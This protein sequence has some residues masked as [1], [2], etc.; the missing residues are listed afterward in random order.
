M[1]VTTDYNYR[2]FSFALERPELERWL[3]R[4]A[5]PGQ[6]APDFELEDLDGHP[7]R[8]SSLRGAPV[9]LEFGSYS[10]PIFSDRVPEMERLAREHRE[11][12]FVVIAVR[13]AHPG[14]IAGP[15]RSEA[16]KRQ[17]ATRLALEEGIRRRVLVDHLDGTVHHAY[18][19]AWNPVYVIDARGLVAYRRAWNHPDNVRAALDALA[20][21]RSMPTGESLEMAQLPGRAAMGLRLL[22]RGGRDALLDFYRSAPP[23]IRT[24]LRESPSDAVRAVIQQAEQ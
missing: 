18:G 9:V 14:E 20:N 15:D 12:E 5:R 19:G 6:P 10:C 8:L 24:R 3:A 23:P 4:G 13:E 2:S 1:S 17:A 16:Q 7:V 21:G 22:E 11:A